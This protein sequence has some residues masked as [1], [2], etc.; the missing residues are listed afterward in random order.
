[1]NLSVSL[2]NLDVIS[3]THYSF[4]ARLSQR[5][6]R[7]R[8]RG[9]PLPAHL[10]PPQADCT[11]IIFALPAPLEYILMGFTSFCF[12]CG[13]EKINRLP[14]FRIREIPRNL[15]NL[16]EISSLSVAQFVSCPVCHP[17]LR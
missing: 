10:D 14:P 6:Y 7:V 4:A 17:D 9:F 12:D 11:H 2:I 15:L 13:R 8:R 5:P 16:L 3:G 1:M